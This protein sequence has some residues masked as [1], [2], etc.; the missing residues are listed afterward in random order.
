MLHCKRPLVTFAALFLFL[1]SFCLSS[2]AQTDTN[3]AELK[4]TVAELTK[5]TRYTE[6]LPLLEK[7]VA[8]EPKN[9]E[10][11]FSSASLWLRSRTPRSKPGIGEHCVSERET[12]SSGL[13]N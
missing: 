12:P 1:S 11:V 8:A 7:I 5:Q 10:M 9:A 13:K 6:A 2:Y 3:L 4:K